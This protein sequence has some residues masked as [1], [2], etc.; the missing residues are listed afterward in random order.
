MIR[1][2][3]F[4]SSRKAAE[5][6]SSLHLA[7]KIIICLYLKIIFNSTRRDRGGDVGGNGQ[8]KSCYA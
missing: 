4:Y 8:P 1:F 3:V 5:T 7:I 2:D 6:S